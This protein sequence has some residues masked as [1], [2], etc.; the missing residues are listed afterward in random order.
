LFGK[1]TLDQTSTNAGPDKWTSLELDDA[2]S[3]GYFYR[4][5]LA[6]NTNVKFYKFHF[7]YRNECLIGVIRIGIKIKKQIVR[8]LSSRP[9][10]ASPPLGGSEGVSTARARDFMTNID[11]CSKSTSST[12]E[13]VDTAV[14]S[15]LHGLAAELYDDR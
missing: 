8:K 4:S 3:G 2:R 10:A 1:Y 15:S 12:N 5:Y 11:L 7:M 6:A 9:T 14:W 13:V